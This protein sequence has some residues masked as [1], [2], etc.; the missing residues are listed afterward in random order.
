[1]TFYRTRYVVLLSVV[2]L[3][4]ACQPEQRPGDWVVDADIDSGIDG[5]RDAGVET[6]TD[7]GMDVAED[8]GS[9]PLTWDGG[10]EKVPS[11]HGGAVFEKVAGQLLMW[12]WRG[13]TDAVTHFSTN[14]TDWKP[15]GESAIATKFE[16][17]REGS[18]V[19]IGEDS[20]LIVPSRSEGELVR[21]IYRSG[22]DTD[23]WRSVEDLAGLPN[24]R[25]AENV[26][27]RV[28]ATSPEG[29]HL[30]RPDGSW[31]DITP[32]GPR[33]NPMLEV[34][35]SLL[36]A[37]SPR[38]TSLQVSPDFGETWSR[39]SVS[40]LARPGSWQVWHVESLG[41]T[42]YKLGSHIEDDL[43]LFTSSDGTSWSTTP[44]DLWFEPRK[45]T[46]TGLDGELYV[47]GH[48]SRL[49]RISPDSAKA[50]IVT[51]PE[52]R[53]RGDYTLHRIGS[54]LVASS[55]DGGIGSVLTWSPGDT[56]WTQVDKG[57]GNP[58][59]INLRDGRL[60]AKA[61]EV[62]LFDEQTGQWELAGPALPWLDHTTS[63]GRAAINTELGCA[64]LRGADGWQARLQ[65]T[66]GF[67]DGEDEVVRSCDPDRT[68]VRLFDIVQHGG[69]YVIGVQYASG[70]PSLARWHP[71]TGLIRSLLPAG[72]F[73]LPVSIPR[74]YAVDEVLWVLVSHVGSAEEDE[75]GVYRVH[76]GEWERYEGTDFTED[77]LLSYDR[78]LETYDDELVVKLKC[79]EPEHSVSTCFAEW[80][81]ESGEFEPVALPA[82]V[83]P[84]TDSSN[85]R[86]F[87]SSIGPVMWVDGQ[88]WRYD[89]ESDTW[90]TIGQ[91][92]RENPFVPEEIAAG[93][94][95]FYVENTSGG[96]LVTRKTTDESP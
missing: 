40:D 54:T 29:I 32:D 66:A 37:P 74:L 28:V 65:W 62:Q 78:E 2:A 70:A 67:Y 38:G 87:H 64:Y 12:G 18:H 26:G 61:V 6:G 79:P 55:P 31:K 86:A 8:S 17:R 5:G 9:P 36:I 88:F 48:D 49:V 21:N 43:V 1:M 52:F 27:D 81:S 76:D 77:E 83:P 75:A 11:P 59:N 23:G 33:R 72:K 14:G 69:G 80:K 51:D 90:D 95:S 89:V 71:E 3:C 7:S 92:I 46:L 15:A 42:Y 63:D 35:G 19:D 93:E 58:W 34:A 16:E 94:R 47:L 24:A 82:D 25:T 22:P 91:R 44:I 53:P 56:S 50:T 30:R 73:P 60:E 45:E 84:P 10:W 41:D 85:H 39:P 68:S 4:V 57:V 20:Y 13:E 96:I